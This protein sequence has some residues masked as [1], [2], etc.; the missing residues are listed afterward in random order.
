MINS[1]MYRIQ[2][3]NDIY[4]YRMQ[5]YWMGVYDYRIF[6]YVPLIRYCAKELLP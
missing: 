4:K 2:L 3:C 1:N 6:D 5:Q